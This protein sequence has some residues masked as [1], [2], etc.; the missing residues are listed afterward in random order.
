MYKKNTQSLLVEH[1]V[2][3]LVFPYNISIS[4]V[5]GGGKRHLKLIVVWL[6][7]V[8]HCSLS[9]STCTHDMFLGSFNLSIFFCPQVILLKLVS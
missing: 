6:Y 8:S 7:F 9:Y 4:S 5:F 1:A 2:V 3:E